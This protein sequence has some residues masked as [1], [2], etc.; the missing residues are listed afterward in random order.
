MTAP[1]AVPAVPELVLFDLDGTLVD[2]VR[3]LAAAANGMLAALGRPPAGEA[4]VRTFVG[5]GVERLVHRCLTGALDGEADAVLFESALALFMTH[6]ARHNGRHSTVYDGVEAGLAAAEAAGAR[7]GCVT[8]KPRRFTEPLLE[9]LSLLQ[10]FQVVVSG[11]TTARRKP[12]PEPLLYALTVLGVAR[13]R[14]L[15]VGDSD[16]DVRAARAAGIPVV[17]VRYGYNHGRD[18]ADSRPD[19]V[20]DSLSDLRHVLAP[21]AGRGRTGEAHP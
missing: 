17:C 19:A 7:L 21:V 14:T 4:R 13:E 8:N 12:D 6:Y 11:D 3:D 1:E 20:L 18:I 16:N 5:N 2:T 10:R 15:L 9:R